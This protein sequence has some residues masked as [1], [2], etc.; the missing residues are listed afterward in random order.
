MN[1]I[2][3]MENN[4]QKLMKRIRTEWKNYAIAKSYPIGGDPYK[5]DFYSNFWGAV[6]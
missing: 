3:S 4:L 6:L 5:L 1:S 2:A